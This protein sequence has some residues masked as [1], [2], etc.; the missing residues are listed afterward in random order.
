MI[1]YCVYLYSKVK[2]NTK[3]DLQ[4][5]SFPKKDYLF[6]HVTRL[7]N[8]YFYIFF[9][10]QF[11]YPNGIFQPISKRLAVSILLKFSEFG[12][13]HDFSDQEFDNLRQL[14]LEFVMFD[15]SD[16]ATDYDIF[17]ATSPD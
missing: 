11:G 8:E 4:L 10:K 12:S 15:T 9:H 1:G 13:Y 5:C 7:K 2:F 6:C 16:M 17:F 3:K 14:Q